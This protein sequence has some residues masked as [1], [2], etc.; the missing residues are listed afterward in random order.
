MYWRGWFGGDGLGDGYMSA[1]IIVVDV[2]GQSEDERMPD[3]TRGSREKGG[4]STKDSLVRG[5]GVIPVLPPSRGDACEFV[6]DLLMV[7]RLAD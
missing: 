1:I 5:V 7:G 3:G 2:I 4:S 6:K